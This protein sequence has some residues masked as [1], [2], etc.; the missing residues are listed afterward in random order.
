MSLRVTGVTSVT[1]A[2]NPRRYWVSS[3]TLS[4]KQ[5]LGLRPQRGIKRAEAQ[6]LRSLRPHQDPLDPCTPT[7]AAEAEPFGFVFKEKGKRR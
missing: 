6:S 5:G 3:V 4:S 1:A 2:A 7:L